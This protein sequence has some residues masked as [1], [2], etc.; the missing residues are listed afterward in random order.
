MRSVD[1][2]FSEELSGLTPIEF[3]TQFMF[4]EGEQKLEY[5]LYLIGNPEF[6]KEVQRLGNDPN[7]DNKYRKEIE[8]AWNKMCID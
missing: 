3:A 7:F 8:S 1:N 4:T 2:K 5:H 6:K